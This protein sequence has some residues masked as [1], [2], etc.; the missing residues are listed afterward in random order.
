MLY[1]SSGTLIHDVIEPEPMGVVLKNNGAYFIGTV[2]DLE[3]RPYR[4]LFV[5]EAQGM[6]LRQQSVLLPEN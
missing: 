5:T 2:I 6:C 1:D 3:K 4:A